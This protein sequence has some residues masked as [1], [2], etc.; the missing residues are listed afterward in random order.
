MKFTPKTEKEIAEENLL[1]A[2]EY[3]FEV[4]DAIPKL[5][6][7]GNEMIEL[8]LQIF[9]SN[10]DSKGMISDYL[11]EKLAYKLRHAAEA[12]GA[13]DKY[14][15]GVLHHDDF[16][17]KTGTVKI[18]IRK[19]KTGEYADQ[20]SVA[21]YIVTK[22]PQVN[23]SAPKPVSQGSIAAMLNDDIPFMCEWRA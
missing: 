20:N 18:V 4:V 22:S 2:G 3:G 7:S 16:I 1:P 5:S 19:D 21:D 14:E 17:G 9:D 6:K 11:L 23:V 13:L 12:M 8:K 15:S 10:A